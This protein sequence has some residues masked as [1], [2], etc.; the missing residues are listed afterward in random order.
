MTPSIVAPWLRN[1]CSSSRHCCAK[2][3][4][5]SATAVRKIKP[6]VSRLSLVSKPIRTG[7]RFERRHRVAGERRQVAAQAVDDLH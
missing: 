2:W 5:D 1:C 4:T 3:N 6:T 7:G